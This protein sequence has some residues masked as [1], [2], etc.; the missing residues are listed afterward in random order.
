MYITHLKPLENGDSESVSKRPPPAPKKAS[1]NQKNNKICLDSL[2]EKDDNE[3][4]FYV[5]HTLQ[6][7]IKLNLIPLPFFWEI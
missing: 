5:Y 7:S 6:R 4:V 2:S 3:I 1:Y